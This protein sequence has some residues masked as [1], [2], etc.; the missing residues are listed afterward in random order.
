MS[1]VS[2]VRLSLT[3]TD[4]IAG[5]GL[6]TSN[7]RPTTAVNEIVALHNRR[8][9]TSLPPFDQETL[10]ALI[11]TKFASMWPTFIESGFSTFT[12]SYLERWIHSFV[13]PSYRVACADWLLHDRDQRVTIQSTAQ[14]VRIVG[15][16]PDHG[17]L[18]TVLVEVDRQGREIYTGGSGAPAYI[19]LQPDGNGFDMLQSLLV[20]R[21]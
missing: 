16:T 2:R 13:T 17:L 21:S 8:N 1:S 18:R 10:L 7:P 6:N 9:G 19:D 14:I 12:D 4:G 20:T 5:C 15:I 3:L 11:L